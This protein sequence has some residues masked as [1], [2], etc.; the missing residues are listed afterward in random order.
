MSGCF[1]CWLQS[2]V[3]VYTRTTGYS[4]EPVLLVSVVW[5]EF[6]KRSCATEATGA[7]LHFA[8]HWN[9]LELLELCCTLLATGIYWSYWSCAALCLPLE[10]TGVLELCCTLLA[11]GSY[12]S[13][14]SCA[15][16]CLPLEA[17]G[18]LELLEYTHRYQCCM[19]HQFGWLESSVVYRGHWCQ[20]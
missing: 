8:C 3:R 20:Q 4:P 17:T 13:Y 7:V 15:A 1:V 10:A 5:T 12:W 9:L 16:L 18:V 6:E 14:W 19:W 2:E 11:T